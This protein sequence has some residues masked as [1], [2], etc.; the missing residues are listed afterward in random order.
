MADVTVRIAGRDVRTLPGT[1]LQEI[2]ALQNLDDTGTDP[3]VLGAINGH[4]CSLAEP[5]WGG[6]TIGLMRLS[7]PKSHSTTVRTLAAVLAV[8]AE[9][10]Y[11]DRDILVDFFVGEGLYVTLEGGIDA[12][13]L[14]ALEAKMRDIIAQNRP[15][16]PRV[17]D[18][19]TLVRR[20]RSRCHPFSS[21]TA[22]Y[23]YSGAPT[24]SQIQDNEQLF[25]GLLL[26]STGLARTFRLVPESPGFVLLPS[27][28]GRPDTL[29]E[30]VERPTYLAAMRNYAAWSEH[31]DLAD[32]G[33]LNRAVAE[34][35]VKELIRLC[36]ARHTRFVVEAAQRVTGLPADG[37][38]VLAAG[39]SSS[40][41]TSFAKRLAVQLQVSEL[42][43]FALSLD[44]YFVDRADTPTDEN[45]RVDYESIDALRLDLLNEHLDALLAGRPVRLPRYDFM[46]GRSRPGG[47]DVVLPRGAP[48]IIEGLHALNPGL[49]SSI[50]SSHILRVYVSALCHTNIDNITPLPT[51][52]SR[53]IRR[54]VRDA[55]FRGYTANQTLARWPQVREGED[56]WIFPFQD[57]A[58]L[59]FNSGLAYE[60]GVLKLWA[61][62]SLAT[63]EPDDPTYG[64]ARALLDLLRLHL[65]IDARLVPPTSLLREFVGESGFSY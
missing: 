23:V 28:P 30:L 26:P 54:I 47:H 41:K 4:R 42:E 51:T 3:Y 7:H 16:V 15:I 22:R 11:P 57:N 36:E 40:G 52:L 34:G 20:R 17:Y 61:E 38:L 62:P 53:I 59:V 8:A 2:L 32:L 48:L 58:D 63:V 6:E 19:R 29:A 55:Q 50:G 43:P 35:R 60:L 1:P 46:T 14:T 10:L 27:A 18:Q 44:D 25:H 65:P 9:E 31:H 21:R 39:P 37:R 5:L 12:P 13:E 24:L 64:R 45:G 49:A 56:R 33:A